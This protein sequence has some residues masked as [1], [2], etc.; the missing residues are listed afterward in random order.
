MDYHIRLAVETDLPRILELY[1]GAR[2][3]MASRG[4]PDQWGTTHPPRER[5]EEDIAQKQLYVV[6]HEQVIHGAFALIMGED[7]TYGQIFGGSWHWDRPYGTIH[8]VASDGSGGI[9]HACVDYCSQRI[10]YLR[11]DTHER[12]LPMQRAIQREGFQKCGII[13]IA[14]GTPRIAFDRL[15][16]CAFSIDL[17]Q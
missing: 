6:E 3:F 7:P 8:R 14:D 16:T 10:P 4:N 12:N 5:L 11:V 9:F 13:Y 15:C 17:I 1:A 2:A